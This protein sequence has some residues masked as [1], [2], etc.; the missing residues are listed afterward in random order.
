MD[1]VQVRGGAVRFDGRIHVQRTRTRTSYVQ[2]RSQRSTSLSSSSAQVYV[3]VRESAAAAAAA[4]AVD[5]RAQGHHTTHTLHIQTHANTHA[6]THRSSSK[7]FL[8]PD[9]AA[10]GACGTDS[11]GYAASC[12]HK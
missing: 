3:S 5:N 12:A 10:S 2:V 9:E 7:L 6:C 1:R 11:F 4:I 8:K